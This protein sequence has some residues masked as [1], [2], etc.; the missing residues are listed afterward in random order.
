MV[1]LKCTDSL[2]SDC[3]QDCVLC[4]QQ[5][6]SERQIKTPGCDTCTD[7]ASTLDQ[8]GS[9]ERERDTASRQ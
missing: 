4:G 6:S 8:G 7:C 5:I 3:A 9:N 1:D 2:S